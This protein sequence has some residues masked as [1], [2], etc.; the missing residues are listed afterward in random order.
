LFPLNT[1]L[2]QD[3]VDAFKRAA[4]HPLLL[5]SALAK[6]RSVADSDRSPH[7]RELKRQN[8]HT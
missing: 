8:P 6:A 4:V 2:A 3:L 1:R 5:E 7:G